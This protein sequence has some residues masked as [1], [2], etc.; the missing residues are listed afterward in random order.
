MVHIRLLAIPL[1]SSLI[2]NVLRAEIKEVV[3]RR[4]VLSQLD[5]VVTQTDYG[6]SLI[7]LHHLEI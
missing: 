6:C 1:K 2:K 5:T 3:F 4:R 7:H